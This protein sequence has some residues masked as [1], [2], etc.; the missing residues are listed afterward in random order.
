MRTP[1]ACA[2]TSTCWPAPVRAA[3]VQRHH[4]VHRGLGAGVA[5]Q[6]VAADP[7]RRSV[8]IP[9]QPHEPAQGG[10]DEVRALHIPVGAVLPEGR[11]R[12][13]DEARMALEEGRGG[14]A[15]GGEA[16]R[17]EGLQDDVGRREE[18]LEGRVVGQSAR[19]ATTDRL[20]RLANHQVR[21]A[22]GSP[23]PSP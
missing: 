16:A 7:H 11:D 14:V 1:A 8:G 10:D 17:A 5:E 12:G 3:S 9:G 4:R 2:E 18:V 13:D 6:L 23:A 22:S 15:E 21:Q 20:P 19:S